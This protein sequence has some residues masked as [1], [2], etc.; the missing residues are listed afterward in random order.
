M[1]TSTILG[2]PGFLSTASSTIIGAFRVDGNATTTGHLAALGGNSDQWNTAYSSIWGNTQEQNFWNGTS[3]WAG[4]GGQF[5]TFYN[6]TTTQTNFTP[7]WNVLYNAT[8]T[9]AGFATQFANA[10]NAT[11][12]QTNFTPN[13]NALYNATTTL[14][15]FTN[16]QAN[17]NTA[18]GW[19][20]HA[21]G[22][23]YSASGGIISGNA[24]TTGALYVTKD[25]TVAGSTS[26]Q[27]ITLVNQAITGSATTT[28]SFSA[29]GVF[30]VFHSGNVGIGTTNP[31][32]K[33]NIVGNLLTTGNAT[34]TL[35]MTIGSLTAASCD[36]KSDTNGLLYCGTDA[37]GVTVNW[38][39]L[40]NKPATSTILNL[41]DTHY[42][43]AQLYATSSLIDTLTVGTSLS[44]TGF[45]NAFNSAVNASTT[46]LTTSSISTSAKIATIVG[47]ETG[48]GAL[49]F[50]TLPTFTTGFNNLGYASSTS[51]IVNGNFTVAATGAATTTSLAIGTDGAAASKKGCLGIMGSTGVWTFMYFNGTTQVISATDCS[52]AATS[53]MLIGQ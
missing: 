31:T 18:F 13:W 47:D 5:A 45:T 29:G 16:N 21:L 9:Q 14:N 42:R 23:Y 6:A 22:G 28:G 43:I 3:T 46:M 41:L 12:T 10:Y 33:L 20:N 44:G 11:T 39:T 53:T 19:G 49:C 48:S 24:T 27:N 26:V 34:T 50:A 51:I 15:G 40:T 30:K 7:N 38:D 8:T 25:L 17:W 2:F 32:Q 1:S 37:T 36:V 4:F 35:S 52:G